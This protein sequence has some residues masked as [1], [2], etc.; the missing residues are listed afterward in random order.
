[1]G[2]M[3]FESM[4]VDYDVASN[5]GNWT[6][7]AGVGADPREDRYFNVYKQ[8]SRYDKDCKYILEWLPNLKIR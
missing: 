6:Y 4:L 5:Y 7:S 2:A 3:Y 8:A 1:M